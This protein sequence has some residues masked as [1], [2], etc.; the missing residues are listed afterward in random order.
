MRAESI[1]FITN[2]GLRKSRDDF[3]H[4]TKWYTKKALYPLI[5]LRTI[6]NF[7]L[8]PTD[9]YVS[10][11]IIVKKDFIQTKFPSRSDVCQ[12]KIGDLIKTK[13]RKY[14]IELYAASCLFNTVIY[15]P[16]GKHYSYIYL[17]K[18]NH[19]FFVI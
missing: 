16:T 3:D 2:N 7:Y 12:F 13:P 4:K 17:I 1:Y 11:E 14:Q 8:K 5:E 9:Q 15:L 6:E 19:Y 18:I 10:S